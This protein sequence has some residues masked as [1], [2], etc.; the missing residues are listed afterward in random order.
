[1][2]TPIGT[3]V[4]ENLGLGLSDKEL[5]LALNEW[6]LNNHDY[7][8][9][10]DY[11]KAIE[12]NIFGEGYR[13]AGKNVLVTDCPYPENTPYNSEWFRGYDDYNDNHFGD[14]IH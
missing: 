14:I 8:L 10:I 5:L 1:M 6:K 4:R 13:A 12:R 11:Y 7:L 2:N 3:R 9:A